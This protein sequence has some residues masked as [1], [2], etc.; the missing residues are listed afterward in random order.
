MSDE[1]KGQKPDD[2][3]SDGAQVDSD[4]VRKLKEKLKNWKQRNYSLI[5]VF[6]LLMFIS[7]I[8]WWYPSEHAIWDYHRLTAL[9]E[10]GHLD[11][12]IAS[13]E[14]GCDVNA[15][16]CYRS[17]LDS[18]IFNIEPEIALILIENGAD[19][20]YRNSAGT[21]ALHRAAWRGQINVVKALL[22]VGADP[23]LKAGS[24]KSTALDSA[25]D[26]RR[27]MPSWIRQAEDKADRK[28]LEAEQNDWDENYI[29]V[30]ALL[31]EA[32]ATST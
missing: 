5:V 4:E 9:I 22:D 12:V 26:G 19:V 21:T 17:V 30:I 25:I 31:E 8:H 2:P 28:W 20:N 11:S 29:E 7:N 18:A 24:D 3:L 27:L 16:T 14:E 23:A 1:K 32:L 15:H 13:I 6:V 10:Y